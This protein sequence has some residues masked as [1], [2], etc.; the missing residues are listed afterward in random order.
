MHPNSLTFAHQHRRV[1]RHARNSDAYSFFNLLTGPELFEKVPIP[2]LDL[3]LRGQS[4]KVP[5]A[6]CH[7]SGANVQR[8][9]LC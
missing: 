8:R 3:R 6:I 2:C 5:D 7:L 1:Q 4:P 9:S